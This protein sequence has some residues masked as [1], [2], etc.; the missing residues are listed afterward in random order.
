[1]LIPVLFAVILTA[2]IKAAAPEPV[3][4]TMWD[5]FVVQSKFIDN[6]LRNLEKEYPH[7]KVKRSRIA[8]GSRYQEAVN[9]AFRSSSLPD[10]LAIP[11]EQQTVWMQN[12][13]F[14]PLDKWVDRKFITRYPKGAFVNGIN[15]YGNKYYSFPFG[16]NEYWCQLYINNEV[17]RKAG[18]VDQKGHT[19]LPKTWADVANDARIITEK[20]K[21]EFYG[22]GMF[23]SPDRLLP[24]FMFEWAR[25]AGC[26]GG[27]QGV[28]LEVDYR[29]GKHSFH[30]KAVLEMFDFVLKLKKDGSIYPGYLSMEDEVMRSLFA[31]GKIG[32]IMG[33]QWVMQ[34]WGGTHPNFKDYECIM[35]PPPDKKGYRGFCPGNAASSWYGMSSCA[36]N[37]EEAWKVLSWF[38]R[39]DVGV[40][41]VKAG[42]ISTFAAAN[43]PE[44]ARTRQFGQYLAMA[45]YCMNGPNPFLRN[46]ELANV[47]VKYDLPS[48]FDVF[49]GILSG[50][51]TDIPG[52]LKNL[53]ARMNK[54]VEEGFSDAIKKGYKVSLDDLKFPDWNPLKPY[55]QK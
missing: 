14:H 20:G 19:L 51:I 43:K 48:Q 17:F 44:Y 55:V 23:R 4:V 30:N 28:N 10:L 40:R 5:W 21:G 8:T 18:L 41:W 2:N 39:E 42:G 34:G 13:Y 26:N 54:A 36:K 52:A 33:G 12:G 15:M 3:T 46:P 38:S 29:T 16:G 11:G 50:Q 53:E 24:T 22:F 47:A 32:M 6:E 45:K 27:V 49:Y 25:V 9:L 37:P 1:M 31:D 7:I 35:I